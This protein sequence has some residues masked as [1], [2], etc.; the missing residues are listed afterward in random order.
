MS[1]S[2]AFKTIRA[3]S[4]FFTLMITVFQSYASHVAGGNISYACIGPN[5]YSVSLVLYRDCAGIAPLNIE[6]LNY[7]SAACN[8]NANVNVNLQTNVDITPLCPSATSACGGGGPI[9][10]QRLEYTGTITLPAGCSDWILSYSVCC[11]NDATTNL[12]GPSTQ[13]IYIQ[14]TINNTVA[15][16]NSSPVFANNPQLFGCVGQ[17]VNYQQ[18]ATDPNGDNLVYS[19]VNASQGAGTSVGYSGAF[20]GVNPFTNGITINASTGAISFTPTAAQVAVVAVLVQEFRGGVLVGSVI[21]DIQFNI[22]NCANTIP[23]LSGIN[24]VPAVYSISTCVGAPLCFTVNSTDA[25]AGNNVTMTYSNNIPGATFTQAGS[26]NSVTGTF[27][28]TP[29]AANVGTH[30]ITINTSDNACPLIGQNAQ[31]YTINVIANPNPPVNAGANITICEGNST[32]LTAT[33]AALPATISGYVWSPPIGLSSTNTVS[34]TASP[35]VTTAYTVTLNYT[36]G[37]SS[38]S[39][40][41]VTVATS[42]TAAVSPTSSNVCAGGSFL[43]TGSTNASGMTF[44]WFN[45]SMVSLG[46]GTVSGAQSTISVVVPTT[47]G[48]YDYTLRVTNPATGCFTTQTATLIVGSP[49]ALPSCVNIYASTT[50]SAGAPGTQAAPTTLANALVL[51]AC[52][53]AVIKLATGTYTIDNALNLTSFVTIEGGFLQASAWQKTSLAGA[54]TI[55]RSTLNP[56][57]AAN[58]QRLVAFYGNSLTGFRMQDVTVTTANA[59]Q[60]GMSTYGFHLTACSGYNFVRTQVL[61]GAAAAGSGDNNPA[62]FNAIWDGANGAAGANGITGGGPQCTCNLGADNGGTGGNGGAAGAGGAN[63]TIIGGSAGTGGNGSRGGDGRPDNTS[64][65]GLN[66]TAGV[67]AVSGGGGGVAGTGGSQDGNGASTS[68]VGNG[69]NG[70]AGAAGTAGV[71]IGSTYAGGFFVPGSATNGTAGRG[72]GGGGG[73]GGAGRDTDGCDAAGGGGSGGGGGGGG[74]GAGRGGLGGGSSFGI[75]LVLNGVGGN[76]LQSTINA[77]A[78]GAGGL[79]GTGGLGGAG[80]TSN[81]GNGCTNGDPDGNRGGRGGNGGNGGNGGAGGNGPAGFS[82]PVYLESGTALSTSVINFNLV[83]QPTIT[84]QNVNCTN[85]NTDFINPTSVTWNFTT[86]ATP[87]S[88]VGAAV[89]TQFSAVNRYDIVAGANTYQ[90]FHNIAFDGSA[91]PG[92]STNAT[93]ISGNTYQIC[94]GNFANFQSLSVGSSYTWDFNGAIANPG[95]VSLVN[96]EFNT[97]GYYTITLQ[98]TTDCCG[99]SPISTVN[100]FVLPNPN[101]TGSGNVAICSG[102]STTLTLSGLVAGNNVVWSPTTNIT[103]TTANT[104]TVN[105]SATT[106][107]IATTTSSMTSSGITATGCPVNRSFVV[108]V[109]PLPVIAMSSVNVSCGNNGSATATITSGGASN[110]VWSNGGTT[111]NATSSTINSLP[112]G[113]YS[114]T[115][116][117]VAS[118]CV[119]TGSVSVSTSPTQPFLYVQNSTPTCGSTSAGSV[120]INTSGGTPANTYVF[121]GGAPVVLPGSLSRTG[122]ASGTYPVTV[123]DNNGCAASLSVT[124]PQIQAPV[125]LVTTNSGVCAGNPAVFTVSG[126]DG[127]V[128]TYN[129]NGGANAAITLASTTQAITVPAALTSQT[130]NLVSNSG[131]CLVPL[132]SSILLVVDPCGLGIELVSF[133]GVCDGRNA[134]FSWTTNSETDND[135][136]TLEKSKNGTDFIAVEKIN[137]NGT[138]S[139]THHY[140]AR[141]IVTDGEYNY[142]RLKQTDFNGDRSYSTIEYVNCTNTAL[143]GIVL[144]PN[145]AANLLN[146]SISERHAGELNISIMDITGKVVKIFNYEVEANDIFTL[147][148]DYLENGKY[149]ISIQNKTTDIAYPISGFVILK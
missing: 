121:N 3:F 118:G 136:F 81:I 83:A 47:P 98:I 96:G 56:E 35:A 106:T 133:K 12:A 20:S 25:N 146:V 57:G 86:S 123:V 141:T 40:V 126:T 93:L 92:I 59:N 9:G 34:T 110:F 103:A 95:S 72:S 75:F 134:Q 39:T 46:S 70:T 128:L 42:P 87:Q 24:N 77:G 102:A 145:P 108:T 13:N 74:G 33:T 112:S 44:Q 36:D 135:F 113:N 79:G 15:P 14:S 84:A 60:P 142:Y 4:L 91:L 65:N 55:T 94:V 5:Q 78:A 43:L 21:R 143:D 49:P 129:L 17:P 50:G 11:R 28:W 85:T 54:T 2:V 120:V 71:T 89:T 131:N 147:P 68:N 7:R 8:V 10:F 61:P 66:G 53:N 90:G 52:N 114:V 6:V 80:G 82:I 67:A 119:S 116:T 149:Y 64:A 62:T 37:C 125:Q 115:A 148:V 45:P 144:F 26:G 1:N 105:P 97:P 138:T 32:V 109:N 58:A 16:C 18:L 69:G 124:I 137:G 19:L 27:C 140:N 107:Y 48:S 88:P 23:V 41:N 111:F 139:E 29:T 30:F 73:G 100:L 31:V 104:I 132:S 38:S 101:P 63:A 122:L 76:V 22:S 51:A 99:L 130:L 127:A 117:N